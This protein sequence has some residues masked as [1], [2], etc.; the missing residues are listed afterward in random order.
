MSY[1]NIDKR[2]NVGNMCNLNDNLNDIR[3]YIEVWNR[4][5]HN[6]TQLPENTDFYEGRD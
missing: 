6:V 5:K 3:C 4:N 1:K 2:V